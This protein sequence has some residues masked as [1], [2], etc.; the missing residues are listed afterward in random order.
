MG[1]TVDPEE[2]HILFS[3]NTH[4]AYGIPV[5]LDNGGWIVFGSFGG[6]SSP[7]ARDGIYWTRFDERGQVVDKFFKTDMPTE[8]TSYLGHVTSIEA[9]FLLTY[10]EYAGSN[11]QMFQQVMGL[12]GKMIGAPV[13]VSDLARSVAPTQ[14]TVLSG[15]GWIAAGLASDFFETNQQQVFQLFDADGDKVGSQ[16]VL[17]SDLRPTF[18]ERDDGGFDVL[19]SDASTDPTDADLMIRHYGA[20]GL[21]VGSDKRLASLGFG[22]IKSGT[23]LELDDGGWLVSATYAT[24]YDTF[25]VQSRLDSDGHA[26]GDPVEV[27]GTN[28]ASDIRSHTTVMLPD[29]GW[30]T[31]WSQAHK[32]YSDTKVFMRRFDAEGVAL[33]DATR[34]GQARGEKVLPEIV[35]LADGGW[36]VT[37][38]NAFDRYDQAGVYFQ[39]YSAEGEPVENNNA[40][41]ALDMAVDV[42]RNGFHVFDDG[43]FRFGDFE[44]DELSAVTVTDFSSRGRFEFNG[45]RLEV[46]QVI[47]AD[48]LGKLEWHAVGEKI[49]K[50]V[51]WMDFRLTDNGGDADTDVNTDPIANRIEFNI[52]G[53]V[54]GTPGNDRLHGNARAN[55]LAGYSGNDE[56]IGSR[57]NEKIEGGSGRDRLLG[58]DGDD[59]IEGG[60]GKDILSGGKGDDVFVIMEYAGSDAIRE[61]Q[62]SDVIDLSDFHQFQSFENIRARIDPIYLGWEIKLSAEQTLTIRGNEVHADNFLFFTDL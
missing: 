39:R 36:V 30:L 5:A 54:L 7:E 3:K 16:I 18:F 17:D 15:G 29:G 60:R 27:P 12:D 58:Q 41:T 48:D 42:G 51:A 11:Y 57:R 9:G 35:L 23:V 53:S 47:A 31:V 59:I 40:P 33:S 37:W 26:I 6:F 19:Y 20:D 56:I 45:E 32:N 44:M 55:A 25:L 50:Q 22:N 52:V 2:K 49:G 13:Q 46:G 62:H 61:F 10:N 38:N 28:Y 14:T 21:Q 34:V 1:L 4:I 43:Q 24:E 8:A